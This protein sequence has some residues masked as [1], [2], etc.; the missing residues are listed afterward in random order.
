MD[1]R[2]QV[3]SPL[4]NIAV[5]VGAWLY[6]HVPSDDLLDA[7]AELG[8]GFDLATLQ[9]MREAPD[10]PPRVRL[11]IGGPGQPT[12]VGGDGVVLPHEDPQLHNVFIAH[13][14]GS[15]EHKVA[16][17]PPADFLSP[18]DADR[19]LREATERAAQAI[20][21]LVGHA[22][23]AAP[24]PRLMVGSLRDFYE[25]P[26]LPPGTSPRAEKLFARADAV[27]ATIEAVTM[28]CGDHSFD[29][30]LLG[31]SQDIRRARMAGVAYAVVEFSR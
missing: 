1:M 8:Y 21:A 11:L 12:G 10:R 15:W 31:L 4:Q 29:H 26:G 9:L 17:V 2:T 13:N 14:D 23:P 7:A 20:E 24:N 5:W 6:G 27:A 18:G 3:W 19:L 30:L 22:A 28:R 16:P 25:T